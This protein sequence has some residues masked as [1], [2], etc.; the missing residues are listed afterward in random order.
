MTFAFALDATIP[1]SPHEIYATW[2]SSHGHRAMTGSARAQISAR[3]GGTFVLWNGYISGRNLMLVPGRR[4]VQSWRTTKFT[5]AD[6]DSQIEV[7]LHKVRHGTKLTL[8]HTNVP[9]GHLHYR[10]GGWQMSY[11]KPMKKF[12]ATRG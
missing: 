1:A 5:K 8:K 7:V 9:D 10:D 6:P 12:F 11:F 3:R 4:I 2:L